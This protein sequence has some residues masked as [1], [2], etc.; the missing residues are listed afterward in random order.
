LAKLQAR[1]RR[2]TIW[3]Y[4]PLA[5]AGAA[6]GQ[7][8]SVPKL[9]SAQTLPAGHASITVLCDAASLSSPSSDPPGWGFF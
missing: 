7:L 5:G 1:Q 2:L 4:R 9:L 6:L 8:F 3:S